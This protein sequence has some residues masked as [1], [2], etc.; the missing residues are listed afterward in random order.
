MMMVVVKCVE[1]LWLLDK[2][3]SLLKLDWSEFVLIVVI[4]S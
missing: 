2:I 4:T 3:A 1:K